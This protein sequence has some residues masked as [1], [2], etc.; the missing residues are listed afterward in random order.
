MKVFILGATGFLGL[1]AAEAFV[2]AGHI[3][4]G[5]TRSERSA[6]EKLAPNEIIPIV[7]DPY[8][9]EGKKVWGKI[10]AQCDVVIDILSANGAKSAIDIFH[11]FLD[12]LDRLKGSPKPTYI[13]TSGLWI[14]TRG[15]GGLDKWTDERQP[16][17]TYND[18][19]QWRPL[20]EVPVLESEKVHG[21]VIRGAVV[22]GRDGS[23][24][25]S[26]IFDEAL[27]AS[28]TEEK[29]FDTV[30][31]KETR[32]ASIHTDDMADLYLRVA[33]RGPILKGQVFMASNQA[34]ERLT[35]ILDA[36]VRVSGCTG[37]KAKPPKGAMQEAWISSTLIK[38]S[39]GDALTGWRPR[40]MSL[41]DGMDIYWSSYLA[42]KRL[43]DTE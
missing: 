12:H 28:K 30:Y 20:I 26:Y 40:K 17:S 11:N 5:T 25:A 36:V 34:T 43:R 3:V 35:D 18:A 21:V 41:V 1:P 15:Y 29:V 19:V 37:Y 6:A 16:T 33:E 27:K 23:A 31:S 39:L 2:R 14:N 42:N 8:S 22:Y 32:I 38:P 7:A 4:Y 9:D 24:F 10:A 13:Y